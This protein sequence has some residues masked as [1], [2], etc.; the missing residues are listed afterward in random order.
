MTRGNFA[1][2][3]LSFLF[4]SVRDDSDLSLPRTNRAK[5]SHRLR[6]PVFAFYE[7][8]KKGLLFCF[9]RARLL[10]LETDGRERRFASNRPPPD[11]TKN[12]KKLKK[13]EIR[14]RT[15]ARELVAIC[16]SSKSRSKN[17]Y[18]FDSFPSALENGRSL[19]T[20]RESAQL[21][22]FFDVVDGLLFFIRKPLL[23]SKPLLA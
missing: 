22:F 17:A 6:G 21:L 3:L 15:S 16:S 9:P 19:S 23:F 20:G 18:S 7:A 10:Y 13:I 5:G 11:G 4:F 8:E 2:F 1:I 14:A 12:T